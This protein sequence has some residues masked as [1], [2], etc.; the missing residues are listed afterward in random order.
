MDFNF[1][2][3][4]NRTSLVKHEISKDKSVYIYKMT[5]KERIDFDMRHTNPE[6]KM[7]IRSMASMVD[8]LAMCVRDRDGN[9]LFDSP[10]KK[11]LIESLDGPIISVLFTLCVK[12]NYISA[13]SIDETEKNL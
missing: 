5:F 11:T 6:G 8:L 3:L 7:D 2:E 1:E 10:E 13:V 12:E 9:Q 4:Q